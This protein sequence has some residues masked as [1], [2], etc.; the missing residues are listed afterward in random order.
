MKETGFSR[1]SKNLI[2]TQIEKELDSRP[3]FFI[4]QHTGVSASSLDKLR[5]KLRGANSRYLVVKNSLG[6]RALDRGKFASLIK[7]VTGACGI[8]FSSGDPVLSSKI[9]MDFSREN[10]GFKVQSGFIDGA[11]IGVDEV[12]QLAN[13]PAKNV[14]VS[15][16]IGGVQAPLSRFVGVLSG[17]LRKIVTVL[18]A[19]A[20]KK[21]GA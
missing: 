2:I 15:Q 21:G 8:A 20:K 1:V 7:H 17:T 14:L 5:V 12:K 18:D 4:T 16:V 3:A 11:P 13:L 10:A 19:I 6:R 9:L